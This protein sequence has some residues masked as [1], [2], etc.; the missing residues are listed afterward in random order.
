M[1]ISMVVAF[2]VI[3]VVFR[4]IINT[5]VQNRAADSIYLYM[6]SDDN[7]FI[8]ETEDA[9]VVVSFKKKK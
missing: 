6:Y 1:L 7:E 8:E 4:L 3:A 9:M 2:I 5:Y